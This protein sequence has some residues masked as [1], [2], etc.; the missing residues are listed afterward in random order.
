VFRLGVYVW[1]IFPI[2]MGVY[3]VGHVINDAHR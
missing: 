3:C 1:P 2:G